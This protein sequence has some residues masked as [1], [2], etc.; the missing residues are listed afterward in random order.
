MT[1]AV[2]YLDESGDLGW[3]LNR[4]YLQGG[5]SRYLTIAALTVASDKRHHPKRALRKLYQ[6]HRWDTST[7]KKWADMEPHERVSFAEHAKKLAVKV[8]EVKYLSITVRKE[9]VQSH[10]QADANKLYNYMIRLLL[11]DEMAK[12]DSVTF[13]P[14]PRSIKVSSGNSL[15]DYLQ[16]T[17]WFDVEVTTKLITDPCDS[18][19]SLNVQF[20]DMLA[21]L[22]QSHY[23][24]ERSEP[25]RILSPHLGSKQLFF[26]N[27]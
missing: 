1:S 14:D 8:P 4:H 19:C 15:H 13:V 6:K 9:N 5:S 25:W 18:S 26:G 17:L 27:Q 7:E 12:Y 11:I 16:G 21:G 23:E 10:I 24:S 2:F 20:A 3:K 22:V